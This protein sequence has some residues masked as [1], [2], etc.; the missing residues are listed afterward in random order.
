MLGGDHI[1]HPSGDAGAYAAAGVDIAAG[2][3]A[4]AL[5]HAS[6]RATYTPDVLG[7]VGAFGALYRSPGAAGQ[8]LV[9]S[10][11]SVGTKVKLAIALGRHEGIGRDLVHHCIND[12]LTLGARPLFFLDYL[13]VGRLVPQTVTEIVGGLA[14][15]CRQHG[16]ALIGGE[17]AELPDL[18]APDD[19]DLA[20]FIVGVVAEHEIVD[21]HTVRAGDVVIGL[22]SDGLHT[23]GY[24]LARRVF[25]ARDL[26][27][28]IPTLGGRLGDELLRPHRCYL[29]EVGPL[30]GRGLIKGMAHITGGGLPGNLPRALPAALGVALDQEALSVPPIFRLIEETGAVPRAEMY[31]VFNMG[32]GFA[33]VCA[34]A[35]R[36]EIVSAVAGARV[37]GRVVRCPA[38]ERV[39]GLP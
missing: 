24:T 9:S 10:T 18:Y 30:L 15:A 34:P 35:S 4:V 38:G 23:N 12:I 33:L 26:C 5:M 31:R 2:E 6:V 11:D 37:I 29:P 20:G 39:L 3:Q 16:V 14:E 13:G 19:Y 28:Y 25:A 32:I 8:V 17:T 36:D 22:P 27:S 7:D 21:G 1:S